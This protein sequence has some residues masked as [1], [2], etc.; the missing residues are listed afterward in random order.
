MLGLAYM[1]KQIEPRILKG[2]RDFGPKEMAQRLHVMGIMR[3]VFARHGFDTIETPAIEY[4][5]T[6]LGKYGDEGDKLT[7]T[8]DDNGGRR[9]A[10]RYDQT[11][12]TARFVAMHW[13][14]L[15]MPFKRYQIGPVWRADK[16]QRGRY[17]EFYQCD[18]DIIGTTSSLADALVAK[19][20][21]DVFTALDVSPFVIRVNS[22]ALLDDMLDA[23]DVT[24]KDRPDV[25][26]LIDKLDKMPVAAVVKELQEMGIA[27]KTIAALEKKVLSERVR[28]DLAALPKTKSAKAVLDVLAQA[29]TMGIADEHIMLDLTLARGLDYYTG[30]IYEVIIPDSGLGSVCGG[31]RYDNLTGL[32][33]KQVF[34]GTGVAFGLDRIMVWLQENHKLNDLTL[35]SQV[36]IAHFPDTLAESM[37]TL[38]ALQKAGINAELYLDAD[39]LPKQ[40][41]YADKKLI[42]WMIL[43]GSD[44]VK[45]D[46]V[47]LRN[48]KTGEQ[49]SLSLAD[50][51][52]RLQ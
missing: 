10:L 18:I 46:I 43:Q 21:D 36:L 40:F 31:G 20:I 34:P 48:M 35:N 29:K 33:S 1:T 14:D 41:K 8:F 52:S 51:L 7:Y 6:L 13:V 24:K 27:K 16:P 11:V 25:I 45:K 5:E 47:M 37:V 39:K 4:A 32:F 42:P 30:V 2:T 49:E 28:H 9:I 15:A 44:E 19:V 38:T 12:P 3:G 26:R 23:C 22:R 17:R 50:A